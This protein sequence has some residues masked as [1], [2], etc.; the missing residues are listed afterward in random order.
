[1]GAEFSAGSAGI[2]PARA[3]ED[4]AEFSEETEKTL[5]VERTD[6]AECSESSAPDEFPEPIP[7]FREI[8]ANRN[9]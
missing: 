5:E 7:E 2:I 6:L 9:C 8:R 1:V 3:T 4:A